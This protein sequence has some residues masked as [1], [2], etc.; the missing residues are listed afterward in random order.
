MGPSLQD[1]DDKAD[2][3]SSDNYYERFFSDIVQTQGRHLLRH[4]DTPPHANCRIRRCN[5]F[6]TDLCRRLEDVQFVQRLRSKKYGAD[7]ADE[8]PISHTPPE[9]RSDYDSR[10]RRLML[11]LEA[12]TPPEDAYDMDDIC[13]GGEFGGVDDKIPPETG[14][15]H[16]GMNRK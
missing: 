9:I 6:S 1:W 15:C 7:V 13:S 11:A 5:S 16:G 14:G 10:E 12:P 8:W 2:A 3:F 4:P